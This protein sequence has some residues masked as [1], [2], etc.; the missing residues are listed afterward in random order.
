M[1]NY[2]VNNV[3]TGQLRSSDKDLMFQ[4]R[5]KTMTAGRAFSATT[6]RVWN[7]L[8]SLLQISKTHT[9]WM[10]LNLNWK[11]FYFLMILNCNFML[12]FVLSSSENLSLDRTCWLI[13][14]IYLPKGKRN[15]V[16]HKQKH[17]TPISLR[18]KH[19]LE[20]TALTW[21]WSPILN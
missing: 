13:K 7:C 3:P 5:N 20:I 18:E 8:P 11:L 19:L 16:G 2:V 10:F 9:V 12:I 17:K 1:L 4:P 21:A 15:Q 14:S 6:P